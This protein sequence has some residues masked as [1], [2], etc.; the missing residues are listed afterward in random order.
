MVSTS[1]RL[2][3]DFI[4]L[5]YL[6]ATKETK[7]YLDAIDP[8]DAEAGHEADRRTLLGVDVIATSWS[9]VLASWL[10]SKPVW[11]LFWP[12]RWPCVS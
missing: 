2:N 3:A 8:V 9:I 5:V 1:R 12:R 11:A 4:W 7:N 10:P 6:H